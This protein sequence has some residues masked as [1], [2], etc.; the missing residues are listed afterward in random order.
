MYCYFGHSAIVGCDGRTLG[1]CATE[2]NG[3]QYA[4]LS[5]SGVRAC[6]LNACLRDACLRAISAC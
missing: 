6:V 2:E 1:E 5:V 4:Q 3:V